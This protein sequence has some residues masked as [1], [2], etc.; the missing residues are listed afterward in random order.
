MIEA[1]PS[2][3]TPEQWTAEQ[4]ARAMG[5]VD[6]ADGEALGVAGAEVGEIGMAG[7]IGRE[8]P[9]A[10]G[11]GMRWAASGT[12][13]AVVAAAAW[14]SGAGNGDSR[15]I[16]VHGGPDGALI[17]GERTPNSGPGDFNR[18]NGSSHMKIQTTAAAALLGAAASAFQA[19][20][21]DAVQ[22]RV[23]DGGNGHWYQ[24]VVA[25]GCTW[26]GARTVALAIGANL[27]S[28]GTQAESDWVYAQVASQPT[29]WTNRIGPRIGLVQDPTG[30][31]PMGGWGWSDGT[32][33][34]YTNWNIDGFYGQPNPVDGDQCI[35]SDF[36]GY[37]GWP[38]IPMDSWGSYQDSHVSACHW[39]AFR[40]YIVEWSADCNADNV[41]DYGQ[42]ID[43]SL[44]DTNGNNTPDCCEQGIPCSIC[45]ACDINPTGI[46]DGADLGALLAFWGP[47][48]PALPR[49]DIN[50]DG[51]VNGADLSLLL[52]NWGPCGL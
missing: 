32:P 35:D 49:A 5:V 15:E 44:L 46:I 11:S 38:N 13:L 22:W 30:G 39:E 29:L 19:Q 10:R 23:E 52:A 36:G 12:A 34:K 28:L 20:A 37:Y 47:V 7:E 2:R 8:Q 50:R 31:E 6:E 45:S 43:G 16:P 27:V 4:A 21:G 40:S 33:L 14:W 1:S 17:A 3:C 42:C 48:S 25:D 18:S 26:T 41:V 24:G 9:N 51:F